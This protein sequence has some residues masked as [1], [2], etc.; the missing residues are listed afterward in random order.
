MNYDYSI[1]RWTWC[2]LESQDIKSSERFLHHSE[3]SKFEWTRYGS[4]KW[5]MIGL[6]TSHLIQSNFQRNQFLCIFS[7][8]FDKEHTEKNT[9][10]WNRIDRLSNELIWFQECC[11]EKCWHLKLYI[12][13]FWFVECYSTFI[14]YSTKVRSTVCSNTCWINAHNHYK[15][16]F[17]GFSRYE[18]SQNSYPR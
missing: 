17:S 5:G 7:S 12:I 11:N 13:L 8:I 14:F 1:L 4:T 6:T 18:C 9:S 16:D 10:F 3:R 15:I 2:L